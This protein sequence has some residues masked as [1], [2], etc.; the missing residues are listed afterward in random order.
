VLPSGRIATPSASAATTVK[1]TSALVAR[2][3]PKAETVPEFLR[4]PID[5]YA[6][7][8]ESGFV[9]RMVRVYPGMNTDERKAQLKFWKDFFL[10]KDRIRA[11]V[12][13]D[14]FDYQTPILAHVNFRLNVTSRERESRLPGLLFKSLYQAELVKYQG[15]W[16]ISKLEERR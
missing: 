13:Y 11:T 12:D 2:E 14:G 16:Q 7:A 3:K 6:S 8:I 1:D 10:S 5:S 4:R 9:E 15:T